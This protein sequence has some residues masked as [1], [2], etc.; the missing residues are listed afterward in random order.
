MIIAYKMGIFSE[1]NVRSTVKIII[2]IISNSY[3]CSIFCSILAVIIIYYAQICY[4]KGMLKKD[5]RCNEILH[6]ICFGIE[7]YNKIRDKIPQGKIERNDENTFIFYEFY[8]ENK[9]KIDIINLS[10]TYKN[11]NMLIESIESCFFINLN[12]KLLNIINNVKNRIPNLLEKYPEIDRLYKEC[13]PTPDKE[14]IIKLD[15]RLSDYFTDLKFMVEYWSCLLEYL[16]FDYIFIKKFHER[17]HANCNIK[18][19]PK[20]S[21]EDYIRSANQAYRMAKK[22]IRRDKWKHFWDR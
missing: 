18:D 14:K 12:F 7:E 11:N 15:C 21:I 20:H 10:M 19:E 5:F 22:D 6:D 17:Y 16:E 4:S 1:V 9:G 8:N 2:S 13:I 3:F